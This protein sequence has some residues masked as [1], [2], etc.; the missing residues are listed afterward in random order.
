MTVSNGGSDDNVSLRLDLGPDDTNLTNSRR[1]MA[2]DGTGSGTTALTFEYTVV[3][4]DADGDG[5][6]LQTASSSDDTIVF[7]ESG[8]TITGGDPATSSAVRTHV[9]PT[10]APLWTTTLTVKEVS[11]NIVGCTTAFLNISAQ[12]RDWL[13][14]DTLTLF[15]TNFQVESVHNFHRHDELAI[16]L[17][18]KPPLQLALGIGN[19][20]LSVGEAIL[21]SDRSTARWG[22]CGP[23]LARGI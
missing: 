8:A 18:P 9:G 17:T 6:W 1:K 12:C 14:D 15:G 10:F 2:W 16:R 21:S 22:K 7:L 4:A 19:L 3:A 5:L 23:E 20:T 11:S 13:T